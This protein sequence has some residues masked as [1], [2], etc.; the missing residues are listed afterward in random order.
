MY[1][2]RIQFNSAK[3]GGAVRY[4]NRKPIFVQTGFFMDLKPVEEDIFIPDPNTTTDPVSPADG[5]RFL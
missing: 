1:E 2:T 4:L 3:I 5:G